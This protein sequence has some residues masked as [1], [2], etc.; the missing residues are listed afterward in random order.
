MVCQG[1]DKDQAEAAWRPFFDW[2]KASP[3]DFSLKAPSGTGVLPARRFWDNGV[4]PFFVP[5]TRPGA[6][7]FHGWWRGDQEQV[8]EFFHGYESVWLRA[9]LLQEPERDRLADALLAASRH[10]KVGLHFNKGLAGGPDE[11]IAAAKDT[12]TNPAATKA[13][14]LAII[15]D[16]EGPRFQGSPCRRS[17]RSRREKTRVRSISPPPSCFEPRRTQD[18]TCPKAITSIRGGRLR[19]GVKTTRGFAP[20]KPN[21]IPTDCSSCTMASAARSG[22]P[23][24]LL[25]FESTPA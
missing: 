6:P 9:S 3:L 17:T 20:S 2:V 25:G 5:D 21:T 14:A 23:M 22:A 13:F 16:G 7:K 1:L 24:A 11:A 12:A 19:T 15:A 18:P 8:G 10:K 4:L